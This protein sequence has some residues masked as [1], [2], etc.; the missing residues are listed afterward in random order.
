MRRREREAIEHRVAAI[1][2]LIE[3]LKERRLELAH[4]AYGFG[5]QLRKRVMESVTQ[6]VMERVEGNASEV[7]RILGVTRKSIHNYLGMN[8]KEWNA[9]REAGLMPYKKGFV[10]HHEEGTLVQLKSGEQVD[11]KTDELITLAQLFLVTEEMR[12]EQH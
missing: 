1:D 7:G 4:K 8:S 5:A 9:L 3:E 11:F 10:L 12:D 6:T 2:Q